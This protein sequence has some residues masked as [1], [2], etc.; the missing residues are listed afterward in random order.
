MSE[1]GGI[2]KSGEMA[3]RLDEALERERSGQSFGAAAATLRKSWAEAR[4]QAPA[5]YARG[6]A[7][8]ARL[9]AVMDEAVGVLA[10]AATS[11][12]PAKSK[13]AIAVTAAA[14]LRRFRTSTFSSCIRAFRRMR[15]NLS[16]MHSFTPYGMRA[17]SSVMRRTRRPPLS[18]SPRA[19]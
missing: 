19:T 13:I 6:D 7:L 17:L 18:N 12:L 3:S 5:Q 10:E 2:L 9:A 11:G 15:S 16:R 1:A 8:V 14:S 4:K